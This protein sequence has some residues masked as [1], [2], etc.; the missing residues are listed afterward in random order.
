MAETSSFR[1]HAEFI[2]LAALH[3][4]AGPFAGLHLGGLSE[5][6]QPGQ[7]GKEQRNLAGARNK[8]W[9]KFWVVPTVTA[10]KRERKIRLS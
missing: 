7:A 2:M 10:G 5:K 6:I 9:D 4:A 3:V 8:R 1:L